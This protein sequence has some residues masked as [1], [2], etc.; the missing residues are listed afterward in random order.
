[1]IAPAGHVAFHNP[2][3]ITMSV[4][5][6][7]EKTGIVWIVRYELYTEVGVESDGVIA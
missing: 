6:K 7:R 1:M 5:K 4:P 3:F 2:A